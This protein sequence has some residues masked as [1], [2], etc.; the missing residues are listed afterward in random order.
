MPGRLLLLITVFFG[1]T[2]CDIGRDQA[3]RALY[4]ICAGSPSPDEVINACT[5]VI[6]DTHSSESEKVLAYYR[7]GEHRTA[8]GELATALVDLEHVLVLKPDHVNALLMRGIIHG[9][10]GNLASALQDFEAVLQHDPE[11]RPAHANLGVAYEK[12]GMFEKALPHADRAIQLEPAE[13]NAR[14]ARCWLLARFNHDLPRAVADCDAALATNPQDYNSYNSRGLAHYRL[15]Q[16]TRSIADYERAIQGDPSVVSSLYMRGLSRRA[17]GQTA[18]GEADI[19]Q[20]LQ[21]DPQV[22]ERYASYGVR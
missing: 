2:A 20:A 21:R 1:V 19:A 11:N 4:E 16:Y 6:N 18:M 14:G 5:V 13:P 10:Q 15:Q 12:L 7:R 3:R 8:K 22:A 9:S 17:L